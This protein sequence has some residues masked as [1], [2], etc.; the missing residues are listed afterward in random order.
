MKRCAL[1]A[2][3]LC[4]AA[5]AQ[6]SSNSLLH[7]MV[8]FDALTRV[9]P[10]TM[11]QASSYDRRSVAPDQEGWF[12]NADWGKYLRTEEHNGHKEY[13]MADLTGPGAVV[14][15]WSANPVGTIRLYFDGEDTPRIECNTRDLL[16][17]KYGVLNPPF[18]YAA[19]RAADLYFPIPYA[20]S[21]KVTVDDSENDGAVHMYYHVGYRTYPQGTKVESFQEGSLDKTL[22]AKTAAVLEDPDARA[23]P[24]G[25][26]SVDFDYDVPPGGSQS[27][28][29]PGG[30]S[31]VTEFVLDPAKLTMPDDARWTDPRQPHNVLR[32]L[33][34][35][36]EFDGKKTVEAPVADFFGSPPSG[37]AY[38]SFPMSVRKDGEMVCR[39]WMPFGKTASVTLRNVN[40][41]RSL[42]ALHLKVSPYRWGRD[43]LYFHSQWRVDRGS[44]RPMR[45]FTFLKTTGHGHYVGATYY[46]A[47]PVPGWWGEGD[48]KVWVDD[49]A[50]PSTFGTGTEDYFGYAWSDP[51]PYHEPYHTQPNA[52]TPGNF[53]LTSNNRFQFF[54]TIPFTHKFEFDMEIWHWQEVDMTYAATT[55]WYASGDSGGPVAVDESKLDVPELVPPQPVKGALEGEKMKVLECTGGTTENQNGFFEL[56]GGEQL[57]WVD[58]KPGDRL[59]LEFDVPTDGTYTVTGNFCHAQDY[60]IH[61]IRVNGVRAGQYDFYGTGVTWKKQVLGVFD[62]KQGKARLEVT[63]VGSN[64]LAEPKRQMFGL[65]YLLLEKS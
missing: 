30:A 8:D 51:R 24:R 42:G 45:D 7:E 1:L 56:S 2:A 15:M 18:G 9:R 39:F 36:M 49:D 63:V 23:L 20:K 48:E 58:G 10:F 17:G 37:A 27:F 28:D 44:T 25:T 26:R 13:V 3:L 60:G 50:F 35:E 57:W 64:P 19:L 65:D 34:L 47:N 31:A 38:D 55:Y 16:T 21:L 14:R 61:D 54:D 5:F 4:P 11:A 46:V 62:L 40:S 12:A 43:S 41:V 22:M 33:I 29:L 6:V 52:G 59:V 53:G 32:G